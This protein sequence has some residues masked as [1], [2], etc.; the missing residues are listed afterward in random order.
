MRIEE[1]LLPAPLL[2]LPHVEGARVVFE[3]GLELVLQRGPERVNPDPARVCGNG[4][5][6]RVVTS[7]FDVLRQRLETAESAPDAGA[8]EFGCE[9][10]FVALDGGAEAVGG[11]EGDAALGEEEI[12][13]QEEGEDGC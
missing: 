11:G 3:R 6:G 12:M 10:S 2:H 4:D 1:D 8:C 9:A 5:T 7:C 13:Y